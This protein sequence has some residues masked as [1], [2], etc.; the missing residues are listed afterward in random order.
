MKTE[1]SRAVACGPGQKLWAV[2]IGFYERLDGAA[3]AIV[4]AATAEEAHALV[5]GTTDEPDD[6]W[7][8]DKGAIADV[9]TKT[10]DGRE[11]VRAAGPAEPI[12]PP[13]PLAGHY[14]AHC[15]S[16]DLRWDAWAA[17][18]PGAQQME[19]A[20]DF[21]HVICCSEQCD[22]NETRAVTCEITLD[23]D[24]NAI[25]GKVIDEHATFVDGE[26]T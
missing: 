24:G 3:K 13:R 20:D 11:Y 12:E 6:H 9:V 23:K 8:W 14:C 19:L 22:G 18:D 1:E 10:I 2:P 25:R 21:D 16:N 15:K 26:D 7:D 5:N 17:F 4:E